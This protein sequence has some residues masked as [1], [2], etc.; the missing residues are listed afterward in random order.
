MDHP[1]RIIALLLFMTVITG[2]LYGDQPAAAEEIASESKEKPVMPR[3]AI[4]ATALARKV[5]AELYLNDIPLGLMNGGNPP[6][7]GEEAAPYLIEG[8]NTLS[9]IVGPGIEGSAFPL[10][11][12]EIV[13]G[14]ERGDI[15]FSDDGYVSGT[16]AKISIRA[17][18]YYLS[19]LGS[20][21]G[22]FVQLIAPRLLP[23]GTFVLMG[24]Q[25]FRADFSL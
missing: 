25:L 14:R 2:I 23:T 3:S 8:T 17:D 15:L 10:M 5:K 24:Q 11:G 4:Y 6:N 22:T 1:L 21:N 12:D 9:I 16:H 18:G 19:D 13:L 7:C 20:S